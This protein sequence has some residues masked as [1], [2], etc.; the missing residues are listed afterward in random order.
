MIKLLKYSLLMG[1]TLAIMTA[2]TMPV[3]ATIVTSTLSTDFSGTKTSGGTLKATFDD[4][5]PP[6]TPGSVTL[7][8]DAS[9]LEPNPGAFISDFWFN[10]TGDATTLTL[11]PSSGPTPSKSEKCD[12]AGVPANCANSFRPDGDGTFDIHLKWPTGAMDANRFDAGETFTMTIT[13]TT[14]TASNFNDKSLLSPGN[15]TTWCTAAHVQGLPA[16]DGSDHLGGDCEKMLD[17]TGNGDGVGVP[18][19]ATLL[20]MGAGLVG[21]MAIMRRTRR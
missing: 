8:I 6:G 14:I 2:L 16:P 7:T 20:F 9:L 19:G 17:P 15:M 3:S 4:G 10:F 12:P 21:L 1:I 11:T 13:D 5:I 18:E